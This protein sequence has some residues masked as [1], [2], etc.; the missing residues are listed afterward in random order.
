MKALAGKIF[1]TGGTGSLGKALLH[2]AAVEHWDC[3]FTVF[4]R[5]EVKQ[6]ELK[7]EYPNHRFILGDVRDFHWL[8]IVLSGHDSVIHAAAYKQVPAAEVNAGEAVE[9]NVIGSRNLIRASL[10]ARIPL[11][12]GISTDKACAPVNC[13]GE[14]KALMEKMFQQAALL[15]PSRFILTRYGNVL[16]SRGSVVPLFERQAKLNNEITVTDPDMTRFW[17]TLDDAVNL[18]LDAYS[19]TYRSCIVVPMASSSTMKDLARAVAPDAAIRVTGIRPGEKIHESLIHSGESMHTLVGAGKFLVMPAY[20]EMQ[21]L[22]KV[23]GFDTVDGTFDYTS[24]DAPKLSVA[25]LRE[26]LK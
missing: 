15:G 22:S 8:S 23:P 3:Q 17:L 25:A 1:L 16:K 9:T 13:Y 26:M 14:T 4:S 18:I 2:R 5:D 11:V 19:T 12:V 20:T 21:K 7:N 10:S 6:G 24:K